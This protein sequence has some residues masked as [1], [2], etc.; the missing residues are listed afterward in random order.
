MKSV[1]AVVVV[2]LLAHGTYVWFTAPANPQPTKIQ[3]TLDG[4]YDY[5]IVGAGSAG[6][7]LANRLS[8]DEDKSILL[9]E[10]GPDDAGFSDIHIPAFASQ[11]I[12]TEVDWAYKTTPQKHA[13]LSMKSR[14]CL[15]P[16]GKVLGGSSS[17]NHMVYMRGS[18][19][20]YDRWAEMGAKGWSYEDVLPYFIKAE[21]NSNPTLAASRYHGSNGPLHVRDCNCTE[22][23]EIYLQAGKEL[24]FDVADVNG[25]QQESTFMHT[26]MTVGQNGLRQ[27]TATAYLRPAQ[28]R[29]NLHIATMT[30]VIKI[31]FEE[32]RAVGVEYVRNNVKGSVRA[33]LEVILSA[34]AIGSPHILLLSGVG[35]KEHVGS[36]GL[37]IVAD[38]PVGESME[39]HLLLWAPEFTM[40]GSGNIRF[41]DL[42]S[43]HMSQEYLKLKLF[44]SGMMASG[45]FLAAQSFHTVPHQ[46]ATDKFSYLQL[47]LIPYLI[48]ESEGVYETMQRFL[49]LPPEIAEPVYA[50]TSG[51]D[52]FFIETILLHPKSTGTVRLRST[53]PFEYPEID[54]NY[55]SH[56]DDV[57]T[58][59]E[60]IRMIQKLAATKAFQKVKAKMRKVVHPNC[61]H[62]TFDSDEYWACL[63]RHMA[64]TVFHPTTTCKM[65]DR[66]DQSAVVDPEL[67]VRGLEGLRVVDASIMPMVISGNTNAPTIMIAEK[68]ADMIKRGRA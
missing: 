58:M 39:D 24:G 44:G 13:C 48:G 63:V 59:V 45:L 10:A 9:L 1:T 64:S 61:T 47:H 68:A 66:N 7:V 65:G 26:Q 46:P 62:E 25:R 28:H 30:H 17:L 57:K 41:G 15:W 5:I 49:D 36:F 31:V 2:L 29:Q 50:G 42:N 3:D 51:M 12:G 32:K 55:L 52:G 27:S 22:L 4:V 60:G 21:G 33:R 40:E 37:P 54:P 8:E 43:W 23:E 18:L 20:D 14:Q 67:R 56:E 34:G 19:H 16:R 11:T 35:P 53:N 38:L 6:C